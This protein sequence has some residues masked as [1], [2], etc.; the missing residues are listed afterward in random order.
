MANA[1]QA[2]RHDVQQETPQKLIDLEC[3]DLHAGAI[4]VIPPTAAAGSG[5][6][7]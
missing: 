4:G 6:P 3:H 1:H 7:R 2:A 5:S